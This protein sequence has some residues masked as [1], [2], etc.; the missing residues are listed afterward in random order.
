[1]TEMVERIERVFTEQFKLTDADVGGRTLEEM[2]R[3]VLAAMREFD[4]AVGG[5]DLLN[6]DSDSALAV[7]GF[8]SA[9]QAAI[10]AALK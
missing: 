1:M 4:V 5:G 7:D 6:W 2:A 3:A 8:F 9:Y 10:D